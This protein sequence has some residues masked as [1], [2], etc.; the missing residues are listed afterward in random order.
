MQTTVNVAQ[1]F[2]LVGEMYDLTPRRVDAYEVATQV[3][4]GA[5]AGFSAAGKVGAMDADTYTKFAGVVVRPHEAV[6]Y[7]GAAGALAASITQPA[8]ATVQVCSMGRVVVAIPT[9][10]TWVDGDTLFVTTAGAFA[11]ATATGSVEV[12]KIIKGGAAGEVAV[13][14][15]GC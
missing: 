5:V 13:I 8:G 1:A 7:G 10:A 6:N 12:G 11:N 15:L 4:M 9:G 3:T 14:E 2:G